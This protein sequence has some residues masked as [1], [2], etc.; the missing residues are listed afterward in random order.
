MSGGRYRLTRRGERV[1]AA[2][3]GASYLALIALGTWLT[4]VYWTGY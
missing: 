1:L 2:M 4:V 3:A